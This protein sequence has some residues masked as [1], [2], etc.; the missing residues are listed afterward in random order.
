VAVGLPGDKGLPRRGTV[1]LSGARID[2]DKAA[3]RLRAVV[4]NDGIK[5]GETARVRL[6]TGKP[7]RTLL[8]P[9]GAV[10]GEKSDSYVIVVNANAVRE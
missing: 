1:S 7:H 4:P 3:L 6:A 8:V 5:S 2:A 9:Q 10:R